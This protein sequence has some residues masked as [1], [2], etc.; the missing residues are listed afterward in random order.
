VRSAIE[1]DVNQLGFGSPQV[2]R[3]GAEHAIPRARRDGSSLVI[4]NKSKVRAEQFRFVC[5]T[6]V[7]GLL[8]DGEPVDLLPD[9]EMRWGITVFAQSPS[10]LTLTMRWQEDGKPQ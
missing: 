10:H 1:D 6:A 7:I 8:Y 9:S 5:D 4:E 3:R 2:A